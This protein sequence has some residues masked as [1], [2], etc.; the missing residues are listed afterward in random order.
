MNKY[1]TAHFLFN[2]K[3]LWLEVKDYAYP[4]MEEASNSQQHCE[5]C[6]HIFV[7]RDLHNAAWCPV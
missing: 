5:N 2:D 1:A 6:H 4:I 7:R 3:L